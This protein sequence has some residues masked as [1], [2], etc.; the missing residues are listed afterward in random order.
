MRHRTARRRT[1]SA[2][3][4]T[5]AGAG[6][7]DSAFGGLPRGQPRRA[8]EASAALI[9]TEPD[10]QAPAAAGTLWPNHLTIRRNVQGLNP[11]RREPA[12]KSA[13]GENDSVAIVL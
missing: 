7:R 8:P 2:S 5:A 9:P 13:K 1:R 11:L 4:S 10:G 12:I 6:G 3:W